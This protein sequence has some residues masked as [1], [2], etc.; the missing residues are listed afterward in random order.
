M[1]GFQ[2]D[3]EE[4]YF[5]KILQNNISIVTVVQESSGSNPVRKVSEILSPSTDLTYNVQQ[6]RNYSG[7]FY[8]TGTPMFASRKPRIYVGISFFDTKTG[9]SLLYESKTP[10]GSSNINYPLEECIRLLDTYS[11]GEILL[12]IH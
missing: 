11:P 5:T 1:A 3:N 6:N 4:K 12:Y 7:C 10:Q 9:K 2:I 8:I